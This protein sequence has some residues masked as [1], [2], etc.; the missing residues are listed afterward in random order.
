MGGSMRR[1]RGSTRVAW[2]ALACV[3]GAAQAQ[4]VPTLE[5]HVLARAAY[6]ADAWSRQRIA[7]LGVDAYL[8]EQLHPESIPDAALDARLAGYSSL[9]QPL[10][11]L[12]ADYAND[13]SA[14]LT[15]L[16]R[17]RLLRA[18]FSHRQ[19]E[20]VLVDFWYDHFNVF[21]GNGRTP[22][23]SV[24]PYERDAIRPHVLGRFA[25]LLR[26]VA[27]SPAMLYYLDNFLNVKS[28]FVSESGPRKGLNE[29]FAR[30]LLELHTVGTAS[31]FTQADV[32]DT[33]R[34][35]TGWTAQPPPQGD[36]DCFFFYSQSHDQDTKR[37]LGLTLPRGRGI[38]DGVDLLNFLARL[39]STARRVCAQLAERFVSDTAPAR[40]IGECAQVFI[41]SGGDLRAVTRTI[42]FS[43]EFRDPALRS[44]KLKRPLFFLASMLR[45]TGAYP[46]DRELDGFLDYL[47]RLGEAP[48]LAHPPTGYPEASSHWSAGGSLLTRLELVAT[49][50]EADAALGIRWGVSAGSAGALVDAL[51]AQLLEAAPVPATRA[52]AIAGVRALGAAPDALRVREA[53]ALLL[54]SPDFMQH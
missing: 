43:R 22:S 26:A 39:P 41:Q 4:T 12:V 33:A 28:G 32:V 19:L 14:P 17:A 30:E 35:F 11:A 16:S 6:G 37:V 46:D 53:G 23:M 34:A 48:Y 2:I 50:T 45:A 3:A 25:D 15:E 52:A 31:R 5:A 13:P 54:A 40:L 29:N 7:D 44:N 24:L 1:A 8:E 36:A 51:G 10:I 20:Q 38:E 42:L 47:R 27:R 21:A 49:A 9:D 18:V